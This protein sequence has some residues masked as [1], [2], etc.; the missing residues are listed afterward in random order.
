MNVDQNMRHIVKT[1][2][3]SI[4]KPA[5]GQDEMW[6][7]N[8]YVFLIKI[9]QDLFLYSINQDID[10]IDKTAEDAACLVDADHSR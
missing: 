2:Y 10:V 8:V 5:A 4:L 9:V 7:D 3:Q 1:Y 6:V